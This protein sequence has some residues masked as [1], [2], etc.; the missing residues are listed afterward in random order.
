MNK[1][2]TLLFILILVSTVIVESAL[3]QSISKPSIPE[4]SLRI[5]DHSYDVPTTYSI[6]PYTGQNI[7]HAGYHVE[8][9]TIDIIIKNQIFTSTVNGIV[10]QLYYNIRQKGSFETNWTERYWTQYDSG[11]LIPQS[12]SQ[13]TVI[14]I[15]TSSYPI[16]ASLDFQVQALLGGYY[17]HKP[18]SPFVPAVTFFGVPASGE[19]KWSNTQT[20]IIPTLSSE[21]SISN[22]PNNP[23]DNSSNNSAINQIDFYEI[24]GLVTVVI[25]IVL[26]SVSLLIYFKKHKQHDSQEMLTN[27]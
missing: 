12:N 11:T 26:V 20:I 13:N 3:A 17:Q 16:N 1:Q 7:T 4:F 6:D 23:S 14:S 2:I 22:Q 8:N 25:G 21:N 10:Y 24:I 5:V 9:K 18:E 27:V 19:S 15:P